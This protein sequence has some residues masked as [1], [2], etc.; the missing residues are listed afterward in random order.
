MQEKIGKGWFGW[1]KIENVINLI[2]KL[3]ITRYRVMTVERMLI[4]K[5]GR[6]KGE[7]W[8]YE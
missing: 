3:R 6:E 8:R 4:V 2:A 5:Q 1:L 7:N